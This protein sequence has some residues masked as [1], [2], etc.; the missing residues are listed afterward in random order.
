MKLQFSSVLRTRNF[1]PNKN[2]KADAWKG[3][4]NDRA[5]GATGSRAQALSV[6]CTCTPGRAHGHAHTLAHAF[7]QA[8]TRALLPQ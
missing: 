7:S 3:K 1:H 8:H 6:L 2:G 5:G 4:Q